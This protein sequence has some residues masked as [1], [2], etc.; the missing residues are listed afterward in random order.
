[1]NLWQFVKVAV[2]ILLCHSRLCSFVKKLLYKS[3][4]SQFKVPLKLAVHDWIVL[5][6]H[7]LIVFHFSLRV[8]LGN[9]EVSVLAVSF[10]VFCVPIQN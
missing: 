4:Q 1:M 7:F 5:S 9:F 6:P 2:L 10:S 3:G 8:S